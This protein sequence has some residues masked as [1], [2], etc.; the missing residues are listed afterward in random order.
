MESSTAVAVVADFKYLKRYLQR[1]LNELRGLG[2]YEGELI[3]I[4]SLFTPVFLLPPIWKDKNITIVRQKK[5]KF[6]KFT[7]NILKNLET[8]SEPN[9]FRTKQ[10][11]WHKLNLFDISLKKWKYI[12]YLDLNMYI[13]Y[14]LNK[15]LKVKPQDKI[16]AR[17]DSFPSFDRKLSSQF[18]QTNDLFSKLDDS[19]DLE[20][21]NYFQTGIL[22]FDTSIISKNTKKDLLEL[23]KEYPISI[24]NEQGIMNLYFKFIKNL[25]YELPIEVDEYMTYFYWLIGNKKIIITKQ[26]RIKYK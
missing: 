21:S 8:G 7:R 24:T 5:I 11:Q 17:C 22:Y 18:D 1:F 25:Y 12:F 19:F 10:F 20:T 6:D 4:T 15:I 2:Q 16:Y 26:N 9:R 3:I 23:A 14:D 13:H